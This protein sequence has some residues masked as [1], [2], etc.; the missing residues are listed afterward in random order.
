MLQGKRF[1]ASLPNSHVIQSV[2]V[3]INRQAGT[4]EYRMHFD[5]ICIHGGGRN[6][7][8]KRTGLDSIIVSKTEK[9]M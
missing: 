1:I 7:Q 4:R 2:N 3:L 9:Q 8:E 5:G 6:I